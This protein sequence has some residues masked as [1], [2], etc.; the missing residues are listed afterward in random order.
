MQ[1]PLALLANLLLL[2]HSGFGCCVHHAHTWE[3]GRAASSCRA[4]AAAGAATC[5]AEEHGRACDNGSTASPGSL[6][7]QDSSSAPEPCQPA[8]CGFERSGLILTSAASQPADSLP[9]LA[10]SPEMLVACA[11]HDL[12]IAGRV[13]SRPA[14]HARVHLLLGVLLI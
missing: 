12:W 8:A 11:A 9:S 13:E 1:L 5:C 3:L 6:A 7:G 10:T 2:I 4:H 14:E